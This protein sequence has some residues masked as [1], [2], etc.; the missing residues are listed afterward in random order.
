MS[1]YSGEEVVLDD[2]VREQ[3]LLGVPSYPLCREDC[4]GLCPRCGQDLN[5][6]RCECD[7][8]PVDPRLAKL[9]SIKIEAGE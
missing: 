4:A 9:K 3:I 1:T 2:L 6:G 5:R 8:A 7:T